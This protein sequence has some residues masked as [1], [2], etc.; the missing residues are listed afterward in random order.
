MCAL[1]AL[2]SRITK[3]Y[4]LA[5]YDAF[6]GIAWTWL[7]TAGAVTKAPLA[8]ERNRTPPR[9]PQ[10][11][12]PPRVRCRWKPAGVPA[13]LAVAGA[14]KND[15]QAVRFVLRRFGASLLCASARCPPPST[16][17]TPLLGQG[18]RLPGRG[19]GWQQRLAAWPLCARGARK[20]PQRRPG[21]RP[22]A[23]RSHAPP[24]WLNRFRGGL[25][26]WTKKAAH[27]AGWL[28]FVCG[29]IAHRAAGLSR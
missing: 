4:I 27:Y 13:G 7:A 1:K 28:H 18:R 14:N 24:S 22:A 25:I 29:L 5:G 2:S 8:G 23:G 15:F 21:T 6:D 16:R 10:Q 9:G 3:R 17:A 26:R 20:P 12:R 11:K 19:A